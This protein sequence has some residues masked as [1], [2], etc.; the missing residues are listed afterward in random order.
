[1]MIPVKTLLLQPTQKVFKILWIIHVTYNVPQRLKT[2]WCLCS[3]LRPGTKF[4][5]FIL[6][7]DDKN[8]TAT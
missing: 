5:N 8:P 6:V 4:C 1:M 7:N 3:Y 2:I